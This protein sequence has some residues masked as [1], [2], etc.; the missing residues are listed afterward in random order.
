MRKKYV[1]PQS[2][3]ISLIAEDSVLLATSLGK[4]ESE[5]AQMSNE[6]GSHSGGWNSTDWTDETEE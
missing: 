2:V 5:A 6:I 4:H 3:A 1:S